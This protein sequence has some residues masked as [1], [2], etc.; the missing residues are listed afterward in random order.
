MGRRRMRRK[1]RTENMEKKETE[2]GHTASGPCDA[3]QLRQDPFPETL[4]VVDKAR[5]VL[6]YKRVWSPRSNIADHP[7]D[8]A[9]PPGVLSATVE[10]H[11]PIRL[12]WE[13]R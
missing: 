5:D 6:Q 10:A 11:V 12:T 8:D 2:N 13:A 1:R 3:P 9:F 7:V 4:V